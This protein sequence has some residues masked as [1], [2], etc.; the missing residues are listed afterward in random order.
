MVLRSEGEREAVCY[1]LIGEAG[2][3]VVNGEILWQEYACLTEDQSVEKV[4]DFPLC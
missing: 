3:M 4:Q 2:T 1:Q